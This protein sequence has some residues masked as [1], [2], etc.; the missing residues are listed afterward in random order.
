MTIREINMK[1]ILPAMM[2][3]AA[4]AA[5]QS[6]PKFEV[7]S[8]K[9]NKSTDARTG[10]GVKNSPG[11]KVS[12]SNLPLLILISFAYEVPFQSTQRLSGGPEWIRAERFD[13]EAKAP[14]GAIPVAA[15]GR[16]RDAI[17]HR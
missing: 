5:A 2:A 14:E 10:I 16:E 4:L 1:R 11:G 9:P 12:I 8:V 13:V 15:T 6:N 17:L 3:A 7:A